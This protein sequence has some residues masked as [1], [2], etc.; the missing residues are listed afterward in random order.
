[1]RCGAET[2][3]TDCLEYAPDTDA[4]RGL[5]Q[6]PDGPLV[7]DPAECETAKALCRPD[8][9]VWGE[10]PHR[11]CFDS[12]KNKVIWQGRRRRFMWTE[13]EGCH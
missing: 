6:C 9:G 4:S 13:K 11:R 8:K 12:T 1:M 10:S 7:A 5:H 2:T 3:T